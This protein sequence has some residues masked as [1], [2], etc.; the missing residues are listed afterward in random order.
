LGPLGS[1]FF[2]FCFFIGWILKLSVKEFFENHHQVVIKSC[3]FIG[4]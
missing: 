2:S 3:S 4:K 1:R